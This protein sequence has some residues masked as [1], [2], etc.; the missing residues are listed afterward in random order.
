M[1]LYNALAHKVPRRLLYLQLLL[2]ANKVVPSVVSSRNPVNEVVVRVAVLGSTV[3]E[4]LVIQRSII[5][6]QRVFRLAKVRCG[7]T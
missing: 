5:L 3:A 6:G 4:M 7:K 1:C 2:E